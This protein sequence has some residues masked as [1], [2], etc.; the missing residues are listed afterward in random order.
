MKLKDFGGKR[1]RVRFGGWLR[2]DAAAVGDEFQ[3][4]SR[5]GAVSILTFAGPVRMAFVKI[6]ASCDW[7]GNEIHVALQMLRFG[8]RECLPDGRRD[9]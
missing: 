1:R 6:F 5:L 2:F 9:H 7:R 8:C 3:L 4:R